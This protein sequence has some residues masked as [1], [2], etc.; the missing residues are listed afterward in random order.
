M[1]RKSVC[2]RASK[3]W[4]ERCKLAHIHCNQREDREIRYYIVVYKFCKLSMKENIHNNEKTTTTTNT[5]RASASILAIFSVIFVSGCARLWFCLYRKHTFIGCW[6]VCVCTNYYGYCRWY[7]HCT[8]T[9]NGEKVFI[10]WM[11]FQ[12]NSMWRV[13]LKLKYS[14]W[15]SERERETE[16]KKEEILTTAIT[17]RNEKMCI[18]DQ[19][20]RLCNARWNIVV[21]LCICIL[22]TYRLFKQINTPKKKFFFVFVVSRF[23]RNV[24]TVKTW[25]N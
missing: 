17:K 6:C 25:A 8:M 18:W 9:V 12:M 3:R 22:H 2:D 13:S 21:I 11:K 23:I 1:I 19:D 4:S 24:F 20:E 7:C 14:K 5:I 16:K 15:S 10:N